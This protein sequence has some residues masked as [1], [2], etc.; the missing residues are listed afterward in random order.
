MLQADGAGSN[1]VLVHH[2]D[3]D[4]YGDCPDCKSGAHNEPRGFDSFYPH[5]FGSV[6]STVAHVAF[7][8]Q[9]WVRILVGLP[10]KF[11]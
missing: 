8:H 11:I 2:G 5:H 9:V 7:N 4:S 6:V 10:K 1:P 3:I